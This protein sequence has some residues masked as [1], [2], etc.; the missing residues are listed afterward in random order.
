MTR[1]PFEEAHREKWRVMLKETVYPIVLLMITSVTFLMT[2]YVAS[3]KMTVRKA[4]LIATLT[5]AIKNGAD[6]TV[7]RHI[8]RQRI[9]E[10][11]NIFKV[12]FNQSSEIARRS[13]NYSVDTPLSDILQ[14]IRAEQFIGEN[15]T[16]NN[17]MPKLD[18]IIKEHLQTNPFDKLELGQRE[19]FDNVRSKLGPSYEQVQLEIT[20]LSDELHAK[21]LAV[22][23]Y[24]RD[25]TFNLWLPVF[26]LFISLAFSAY[27]LYQG[28]EKRVMQLFRSAFRLAEEKA[29]YGA[30]KN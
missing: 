27:Q 19:A 29:G 23:K 20:R 9:P 26:A 8:Y 30:S 15:D 18:K 5:T 7:V 4:P 21:N 12:L 11:S 6:L 16:L 14:D 24:L 25:S 13:D 1:D 28:R 17:L 2:F 10:R 3:D 22:E